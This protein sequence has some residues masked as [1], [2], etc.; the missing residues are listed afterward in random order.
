MTVGSNSLLGDISTELPDNSDDAD[1]VLI[2]RSQLLRWH[3]QFQV[4]GATD[5]SSLELRHVLSIDVEGGY[6]SSP[7]LADVPALSDLRSVLFVEYGI[8]DRLFKELRRKGPPSAFGD[9]LELGWPD[10]TI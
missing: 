6:V 1:D 3:P 4:L 7:T 8:E 5:L 2:K 9:E 10:W